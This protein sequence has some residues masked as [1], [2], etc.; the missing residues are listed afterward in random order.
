MR[1]LETAKDASSALGKSAKMRQKLSDDQIIE[2]GRKLR[3]GKLG[4]I[5]LCICLYSMRMYNSKSKVI[6]SLLVVLTSRVKQ[7]ESEL[8]AQ[9]VGNALYGLQS[10]E[11]SPELRA[12]LATLAPMIAR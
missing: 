1:R 2:V 10:F 7:L 5:D 8:G 3:P 6:L 11:D 4:M 9:G 12:I